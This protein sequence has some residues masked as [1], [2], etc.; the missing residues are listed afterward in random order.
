MGSPSTLLFAFRSAFSKFSTSRLTLILQGMKLRLNSSAIY[1]YSYAWWTTA[2][3][4]SQSTRRIS[5]NRLPASCNCCLLN[6][7]Q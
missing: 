3:V 7:D 2:F 6:Q 4:P 5:M 1:N